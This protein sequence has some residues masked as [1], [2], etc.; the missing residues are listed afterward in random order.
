MS[1]P[2]RPLNA[3]VVYPDGSYVPIRA[4]SYE[5]TI[6]GQHYWLAVDPPFVPWAP[7]TQAVYDHNGGQRHVIIVGFDIPDTELPFEQVDMAPTDLTAEQLADTLRDIARRVEQGDSCEGK[8]SYTFSAN[9]PQRFGVNAVYRVGTRFGR[10]FLRLVG[11]PHSTAIERVCLHDTAGR[12]VRVVTIGVCRP[13]LAA[14]TCD[15]R[16]YVWHA[17]SAQYREATLYEVGHQR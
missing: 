12:P 4:L 16:V 7:G 13:P 2:A 3:R 5:M 11:D 10:D 8:L 14:I 15:G 1:K 17:S 9:D 6:R